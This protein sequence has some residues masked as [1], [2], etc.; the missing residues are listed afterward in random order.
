MC[1]PTH[2]YSSEEI[3]ST[4]TTIINKQIASTL[5]CSRKASVHGIYSAE[6][7]IT[8]Y[9]FMIALMVI[10]IGYMLP[11]SPSYCI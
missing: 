10:I 11:S 8:E 3:N 4:Y 1:F 2:G 5:K 6:E 7:K 9:F